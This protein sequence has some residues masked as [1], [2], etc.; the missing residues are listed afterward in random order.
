MK[1]N[2]DGVFAQQ[3]KTA[4]LYVSVADTPSKQ[5]HGLMF[6]KSM[7]EDEGMYF[8][9]SRE[10]SLRFWG[11]NTFMP[12]DIAFADKNGI[13][14]KIDHITPMS[15]TAVSS[16]A[17]C[18]FAIEA[19]DGF[20]R[21]NE[22]EVGDKVFL[23]RDGEGIRFLSFAKKR[24]N[25]GN[26]KGSPTDRRIIAQMPQ[27]G[28]TQEVTQQQTDDQN[29]PV[30]DISQL[31]SIL[32]DDLEGQDPLGQDSAVPPMGDQPEGEEPSLDV[33]T[34]PEQPEFQYPSFGN[35]FDA[36]EWAEQNN[37]V[38]RISYTTDKGTGVIRDIEPH[39]SFHAKSTNRQI[40]VTF[41]ESV[42]DVRAFIMTN[43]G[44]FSF[45]GERFAKKFRVA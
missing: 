36:V 16:D 43:I 23:N 10:Q 37:E 34:E 25:Q 18:R 13:I 45:V 2:L 3:Q 35:V 30:L 39:G 11:E 22:I 1:L 12:L 21:R 42:G 28:P 38:M 19:N 5:Q 15:R 7:P 31:G 29:L 17:P 24:R 33:S 44:A 26:I 40:L 41:D 20:F 27:T 6:R 14:R 4:R 32:E 9:F 8:V